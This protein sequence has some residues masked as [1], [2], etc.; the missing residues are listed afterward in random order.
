[1][2]GKKRT[3][4]SFIL[5]KSKHKFG[6][7]E[8]REAYKLESPEFQ[9]D[10]EQCA[11]LIRLST[12]NITLALELCFNKFSPHSTPYFIITNE[13][14]TYFEYTTVGEQP[15]Q[16]PVVPLLSLNDQPSMPEPCHVEFTQPLQTPSP[17]SFTQ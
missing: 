12:T 10:Y 9:I 3:P 11:E 1:Y 5:Y 16:D 15:I 17:E 13:P 2:G 8:A 4:S 6:A 7:V 14:V